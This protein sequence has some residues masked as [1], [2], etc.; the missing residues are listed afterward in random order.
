MQNIVRLSERLPDLK[1]TLTQDALDKVI[2]LLLTYLTLNQLTY[3]VNSL[4]EERT[5]RYTDAA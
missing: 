1:K 2:I 3:V 4:N 5:R